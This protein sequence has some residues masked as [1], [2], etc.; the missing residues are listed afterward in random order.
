[1]ES[2]SIVEYIDS[3]KIL[4]A[5]VLEVK[6]RRLRLLTETNREVNLAASRLSHSCPVRLDLNQA[7]DRIVD[8]LK[9]I[10]L[11]R[12]ELIDRVDIKELWDVLNTEQEW[13]D[14]DTMTAFCFPNSP[15]SD[16]Q[17][18]VVRAFFRNRLYFKFNT[19]RFFPYT[20]DQVVQLISQKREAE[21]R[22]RM[23]RR[24]GEWLRN[25]PQL[26]WDS[27]R[28]CSAEELE[29]IE[30]LQSYYLF[31]KDSP[32][33]ALGKAV[34][35]RAGARDP[36]IVFQFMVAIG[37]WDVNQN[38]ELLQ[39]EV[40]LEFAPEV[41]K[42]AETLVTEVQCDPRSAMMIPERRDLTGLTL[43]TIDG[44]STLDFD[45]AL[46]IERIGDQYRLGIHIVDVAQFVARDC[47]IDSEALSRGSSIYMPDL[48]IPMLPAS[49]AE[50]VCSLK[51][52]ELRPAVTTMVRMG[53]RLN[54]IDFEV[55]PSLVKVS[56]QL[57]YYDVNTVIDESPDMKL[58]RDIATNFRQF[59]LDA[60]AVQI[61]LPDIHVWI[62]DHG[63]V[64]LNRI[65]RESPGRV[66]VSECMIMAN[67]LM[68][69]FLK[70]NDLPAIFRSQ[71]D[72]R[73]RLY[74]GNEG[75]LFQNWMQ[76]RLLSRFVLGFEP[77]K[78]S[79]LG[80]KA[81][82]TATSPIRKY[83]DLIT[84][85]QIRSAFGLE[86]PYTSEQIENIIRMLEQ[87]MGI[88]SRLQ[89]RR[90]RYWVLKYLEG[91][92]GL[93]VEAIVLA[94]R[95]NSYQVLIPDFM[96]ECDMPIPGNIQLKPEDMVRVTI[97]NVN[98]R[99]DILSIYMG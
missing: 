37:Q 59:R 42:K 43:M 10:S 93:K 67:W 36:G 25:I 24:G 48:K 13:I 95:R 82:I 4:C 57:S 55:F 49:L 31:G 85:R 40:A 56:R 39:Y 3:Q 17:S 50:D 1:M 7:R 92:I 29:L 89:H 83:G 12:E 23:I 52:G 96:I 22:E 38:T 44:Q 74:T 75:S 84:Q 68:A 77:E 27:Q 21:R 19:D 47:P 61:S 41:T 65:N 91:Q 53:P 9:E 64:S 62:D 32:Y 46:S 99:K 72:P 11:R 71:P 34:L 45:D 86:T 20:E 6:D 51:A 79:G 88:V 73:E 26:Q 35:S 5:V 70:T 97:Q 98:A 81:Y 2:G 63:Q 33:S 16:H 78:H 76:R 58:L 28:E 18:A 8:M 14:L 66:L 69:R 30:A 54:L 60:G 90:L 87:P 80:L 94:K 15:T